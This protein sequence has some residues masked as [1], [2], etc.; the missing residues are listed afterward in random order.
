MQFTVAAGNADGAPT[1]Q[2]NFDYGDSQQLEN[3]FQILGTRLMMSIGG[4]SRWG[5]VDLESA[6]GGSGKGALAAAA[7]GGAVSLFGQKPDEVIDAFMKEKKEGVHT[8]KIKLSRKQYRP[9]ARKLLRLLKAAEA[10]TDQE[11]KDFRKT[12]LRNRHAIVISLRYSEKSHA[13]RIRLKQGKKGIQI[14][15]KT[16][17]T[18]GPM[19]FITADA[20]TEAMDLAN[21]DEQ[22]QGDFYSELGFLVIKITSFV[23]HSSL[24][25]LL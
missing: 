25:K 5:W 1:L 18:T 19:E 16:A 4:I 13:L 6:L 23:K 9:V 2:T 10:L 21:M 11:I 3:S 7:L 14:R 8:L 17:L 24:K 20:G 22:T 15:A 12:F